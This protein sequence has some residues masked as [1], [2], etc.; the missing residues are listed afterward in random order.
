MNTKSNVVYIHCQP[1]T[2]E[3]ELR[4]F[5]TGDPA[6]GY[7]V[8]GPYDANDNIDRIEAVLHNDGFP[9]YVFP[10]ELPAGAPTQ[11]AAKWRERHNL[12]VAFGGI[13][14]DWRFAGPFVGIDA[15]ADGSL[16][17]DCEQVVELEQ[18]TED[19]AVDA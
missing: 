11:S 15:A 12:F 1:P 19:E 17:N 3:A 5:V 13:N 10:L 4:V 14:V 9:I 16:A 8:L 2:K 7:S 6:Y 18:V